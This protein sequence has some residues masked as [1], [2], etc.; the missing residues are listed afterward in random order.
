MLS[1]TIRPGM[2]KQLYMFA[3][4]ACRKKNFPFLV[5]YRNPTIFSTQTRENC[6]FSGEIYKKC[7][8]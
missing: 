2:R 3:E 5:K 1:G 7:A 8:I 4:T 6:K